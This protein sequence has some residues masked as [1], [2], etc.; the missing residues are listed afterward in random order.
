MSKEW[1]VGIGKVKYEGP[2]SSNP[3][4]F[5]YYNADEIVLGKTMKDWLRFAVCYWHTWRGVGVDM[6][7]EATQQRPWD[8]G[9]NSIENALRRVDVH[10][11]FLTKL[12]IDYFT[13]H[14]RDVA[15]QGAT[16]QETN[17]N[18]DAVVDY[19]QK[20]M[21][22]TKVKLLW[23]TANLFSNLRYMNGAATNPDAH[24]FAYA[25]AQVRKAIEVSHRLGAENYVFWGGREGYQS[26]LNTNL[27][28]ELE[29]LA[30]FLHMAVDYKK[31]I[32]FKGQFLI[33]P[34]P[35]EPTKHQYDFDS[36]TVIG[37]LKTHGL[38]KDYKLNIETNHA[39]LSGHTME[40][41]LAVAS[42]AGVLGSLDSNGGDPLL[43]WDVDYFPTDVKQAAL[44]MKYVL[45][46]GGLA[47]G[48]LNFDSK[49]RREST[50]LEDLFIG[51]INGMDTF[52]RALRIAARIKTD[53][54][55]DALVHQRY[56]SFESGLGERIRKGQATFEDC[57]KFVLEHGEPKKI[58]AKQE[59]F[60]SLVNAYV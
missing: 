57:E 8:D 49:L 4:A 59:Q 19:I 43:G 48:G 34:K 46:Q 16:L 47:P 31:K 7:G 55:L 9:S 40:H 10:F 13:F 28:L 2:T 50:D 42:N 15:P 23:G 22:E 27:G 44:A 3:M 21:A 12:G 18:L 24:V 56:A 54:K 1:F 20:K 38:D 26:L 37:F 29:N 52:A 51:H 14:D 60:E 5:H 45:D 41:E 32:G 6:F 11:E 25:A 36:A 39:L 33:E 30:R 58:S 53:G 35:R 17:K